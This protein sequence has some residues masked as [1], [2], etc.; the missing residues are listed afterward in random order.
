MRWAP[1][2]RWIIEQKAR[3]SPGS[4]ASDGVCGRQASGPEVIQS[5]VELGQGYLHLEPVRADSQEDAA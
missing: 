5:S 4:A 3:N 1:P 2:T